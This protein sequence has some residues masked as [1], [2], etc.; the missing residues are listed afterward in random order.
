[1]DPDWLKEDTLGQFTDRVYPAESYGY[2]MTRTGIATEPWMGDEEPFK[3]G[4]LVY[5][6][7]PAKEY[8]PYGSRA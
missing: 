1:M 4:N 5:R 8:I 7:D 6:M 3:G 2:G